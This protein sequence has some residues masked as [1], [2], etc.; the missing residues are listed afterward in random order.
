MSPLSLSAKA[1]LAAAA[2]ASRGWA[3]ERVTVNPAARYQVMD[4]WGVSLCWWANAVGGWADER[5]EAV[6]DLIFHPTKGLG[7][8]IVRYN[9]GGG[10]APGH[11]HMRPGGAVPGYRPT[12]DGAYDWAADARQR[13]MLQAAIA[14]GA[15]TS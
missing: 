9:I 3:A 13:W 8:N 2:I 11:K 10:D 14:R 1:V 4:G 5:R 12:P 6:A 7:L 15:D